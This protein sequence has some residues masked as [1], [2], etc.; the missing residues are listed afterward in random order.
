MFDSVSKWLEKLEER[1]KGHSLLVMKWL[2]KIA[3]SGPVL[4]SFFYFQSFDQNLMKGGE[5]LTHLFWPLIHDFNQ[6]AS[7]RSRNFYWFLKKKTVLL[8]WTLFI[9][10]QSN[11]CL[12]PQNSLGSA[13]VWL[14]KPLFPKAFRNSAEF[15]YAQVYSTVSL[16]RRRKKLFHEE[17]LYGRSNE[18]AIQNSY[19]RRATCSLAASSNSTCQMMPDQTSKYVTQI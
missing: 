3:F 9:L 17:N 5:T 10:I 4:R 1:R 11:S 7:G 8:Q 18:F 16:K 14:D 12:N 13:V 15:H 19:W 6:W 2:I